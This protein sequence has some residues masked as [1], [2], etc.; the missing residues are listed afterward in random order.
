MPNTNSTSNPMH[1]GWMYIPFIGYDVNYRGA[2]SLEAIRDI[3]A[4]YRIWLL[5]HSGDRGIEWEWRTGHNVAQ[6]VYIRDEQVALIFRLRF[7]I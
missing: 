1:D 5:S 7:G 4:D 3:V 6:G 2:H